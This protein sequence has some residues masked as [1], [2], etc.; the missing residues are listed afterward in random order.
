MGLDLKNWKKR[1]IA[2]Y[3]GQ[4]F[5]LLGSSAA[6]F[7]LIWWLTVKTNSAVTLTIAA[8]VGLLPQAL[9]GP[10]AGV[11]VDRY[12]RKQIM[13]ASDSF[14]ALSSAALA[15]A[16]L[17]GEPPLWFLYLM[18]F[19]RALG[20]TFQSPAMQS[21]IPLLVPEQAL[22]KVGGWGQLINS[23]A[24]MLGPVIGAAMMAFLP[25]SAIMLVD[26]LGAG[27]A[28]SILAPIKIPDPPPQKTQFRF[29]A[30]MAQGLSALR[31]NKPLLAVTG[32]ILL[33]CIVFMPLGSLYPLLVRV[34]YHGTA[35][36]NSACEFVFAGGMLIA[37]LAVGVFGGLKRQFLMISLSLISLG[38]LSAL[39]GI[40]PSSLFPVFLILSFFMGA[41][42]TFFNV[43]YNAYIQK[44]IPAESLGKVF[45]LIF[46]AMSL[47][48]PV[49]LALAGPVSDRIGIDNWFLFSG[50]LTGAVGVFCCIFTRKYEKAP[51]EN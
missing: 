34:H 26:I 7:A 25:L 22:M 38:T 40:L 15:L 39:C 16:F 23:G 43:P 31:Q 4:A 51:L 42:G 36:H 21:S 8:A 17:L 30:D 14:V 19:F 13:I 44:T 47:T 2:I 3:A 49:G 9:L 5:S 24:M 35:W 1:F 29:F 18:M 28:V 33:S 10:F 27:L 12:S 6:Q 45:T 20:G 46:S 11:F 41:T 32:P 50:I 37:S 48:S